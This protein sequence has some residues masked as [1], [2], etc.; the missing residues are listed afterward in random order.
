MT[1]TDYSGYNLV[2]PEHL[3]HF[4][5][6]FGGQLLKWVDE[7]AWLVATREYPGCTFVTRAMQD[8]QFRHQVTQGTI[9]RLAAHCA[10]AGKTAVH[11]EVRVHAQP[12]GARGENLVFTTRVTFVNIAPTGEKAPIAPGTR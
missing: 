12:P 6:L 5:N 10:E 7:F 9:L 8:V 1:T 3:N 4:G 11:Y 2:R